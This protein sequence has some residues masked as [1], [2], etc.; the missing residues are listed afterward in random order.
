M[1]SFF[2]QVFQYFKMLSQYAKFSQYAKKKEEHVFLTYQ[3]K[4]R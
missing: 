4:L 1:V 2:P 3:L